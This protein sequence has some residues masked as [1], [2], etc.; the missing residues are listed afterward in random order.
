MSARSRNT[1]G[2]L[3]SLTYSRCNI[4]FSLAVGFCGSLEYH[5]AIAVSAVLF[6][7][8]PLLLRLSQARRSQSGGLVFAWAITAIQSLRVA[9]MKKLLNIVC[10]IGVA[11]SLALIRFV[12]WCHFTMDA[13]IRIPVVSF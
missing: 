12:V 1:S 2:Y 8:R 6:R 10:R 3:S 7:V 4:L 11:V 5:L 13:I 9:C